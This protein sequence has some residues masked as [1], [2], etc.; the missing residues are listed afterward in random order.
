MSITETDEMA[1]V[2]N[3]K[4]HKT[5]GDVQNEKLKS[6]TNGTLGKPNPAG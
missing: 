4:R 5:K 1:N 3:G 6:Q 2:A